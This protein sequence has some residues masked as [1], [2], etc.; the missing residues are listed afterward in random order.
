[1]TAVLLSGKRQG[2]GREDRNL[3][4]VFSQNYLECIILANEEMTFFL[5]RRS[6][7]N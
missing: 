2:G 7:L 4:E 3:F 1:M 5:S 6:H